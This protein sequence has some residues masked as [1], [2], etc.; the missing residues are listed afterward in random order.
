MTMT[1]C[2]ELP[3]VIQNRVLIVLNKAEQ[4]K[5]MCFGSN[6]ENKN[7]SNNAGQ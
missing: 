6:W 1:V 3:N 7:V 4:G 2:R 5:A